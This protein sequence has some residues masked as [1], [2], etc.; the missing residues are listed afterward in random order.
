MNLKL[1]FLDAD[2]AIVFSLMSKT[3]FCRVF[4]SMTVYSFG[5]E[6]L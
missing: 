3:V 1:W 6:S 2:K 5:C 4:M